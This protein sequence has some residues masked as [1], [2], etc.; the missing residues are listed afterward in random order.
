MG[1]THKEQIELK[2]EIEL[3]QTKISVGE[4]YWHHKSTMSGLL[5]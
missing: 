1:R 4:L 5:F 2:K 3:A